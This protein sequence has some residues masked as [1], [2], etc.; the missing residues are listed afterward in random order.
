LTLSA[1]HPANGQFGGH[2]GIEVAQTDAGT[3]L[4]SGQFPDS[5]KN[6][7]HH[8]ALTVDADGKGRLYLNGVLVAIADLPPVP[9]ASE[10]R[11]GSRTGAN[12][13]LERP[14]STNCASTTAASTNSTSAR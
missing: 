12:R 4:L 1:V 5:T 8:V 14:A 3:A 7:W 6:D 11:L 2:E 9:S 13:N 10:L